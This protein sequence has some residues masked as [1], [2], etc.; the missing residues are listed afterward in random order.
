MQHE[1]IVVVDT[2]IVQRI[3]G[4]ENG[5]VGGGTL[6]EGDVLSSPTTSRMRLIAAPASENGSSGRTSACATIF[7]RPDVARLELITLDHK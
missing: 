6:D 2:R 7:K 5:L 3:E 4:S 1:D